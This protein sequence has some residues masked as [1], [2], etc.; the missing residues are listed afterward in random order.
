M[1]R[2]SGVFA[3]LVALAGVAVFSSQVLA[4]RSGPPSE[5]N[6]S[7]ASGG[8]SC[9]QCHGSA[10]GSGSVQ[11]LGAPGA[12]APSTTYNLTVRIDDPVQAGAGFEL[13]VEDAAGPHV[14]TLVLSDATNTQFLSDD[15]IDCPTNDC[16]VSHTSTGVTTSVADWGTMGNAAI[17]N[18]DWTSPA[19]DVGT[20]TFWAVGNAINDNFSSSGDIVYLTNTSA[21]FAE[22]TPAASTWGLAVLTLVML[23]AGSIMLN[24]KAKPIRVT[25]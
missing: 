3:T 5:R 24:R 18:V 16:F 22:P 25:V 4:F 21:G 14:G 9:S 1:T 15:P 12:Y 2:K 7:T 20:V 19:S 13:S 11:I 17:F 10:V 23:V 8:Q 6:G